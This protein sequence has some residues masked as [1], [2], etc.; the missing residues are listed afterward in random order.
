MAD[1][2]E[3]SY[4]EIA[5]TNRQVMSIFVVLLVFVIAAFLGGVW[6]GRGDGAAVTTGQ[7]QIIASGV[8]P[9]EPPL[10]QLDF[11]DQPGPAETDTGEG[12]APVIEE[13]AP[14][15]EEQQPEP[16]LEET[17]QPVILEQLGRAA[18][19]QVEPPAQ[20]AP[21]TAPPPAIVGAEA[22]VVQVFSSTDQAQAQRILDRVRGGGYPAV[23]SSGDVDGRPMYRVRVGPYSDREEAQSVADRIRR[24]YRLDTWIT[25]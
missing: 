14:V 18:A 2:R 11:F 24:A 4:Y 6:V 1:S 21:V 19:A 22:L 17:T 3:Q 10:Q 20:S 12:P 25:R 7:P 15:I 23:M 13:Q 16:I 8:E 9:G 5:L